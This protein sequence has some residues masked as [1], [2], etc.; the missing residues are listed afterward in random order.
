MIK[1]TR[2]ILV[3]KMTL[4]LLSGAFRCALAIVLRLWLLTGV[5]VAQAPVA[6]QRQV[7][8]GGRA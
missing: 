5:D 2:I 6:R 7:P 8:N 3:N 4:S 1:Q